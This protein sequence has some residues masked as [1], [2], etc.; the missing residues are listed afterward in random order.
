MKFLQEPKSILQASDISK[1]EAW[2]PSAY[3]N[4][5]ECCLQPWP[6]QNRTTQLFSGGT[7]DLMIIQ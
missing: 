4:I 3:L 7:R 6:S 1:E 2:F 5:N